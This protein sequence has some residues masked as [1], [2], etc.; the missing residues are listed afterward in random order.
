M[1][2][3]ARAL[4]RARFA[5]VLPVH[6]AL[7]M[8]V[9]RSVTGSL[10]G[11]WPLSAEDGVNRTL[12]AHREPVLDGF[13]QWLSLLANTQVITGLTLACVLALLLTPPAPRWAEAGFLAA[14][15]AVQS[16]MFLL[17]TLV[18][19]RPRPDV[20]HLDLAPP[21]SSFPSGHVGAAVA[22]YGGLAVL[23]RVGTRGAWR[24]PV[25]ALLLL[26]PLAVATSRLYRGMHHPSDVLGGLLNGAVTLAVIGT[27]LLSG[28]RR[29]PERGGAPSEAAPTTPAAG[30]S[31]RSSPN[32]PA[33]SGVGRTVVV[34]HPHGCDDALAERVGAVLTRHGHAAQQWIL[35]GEDL[36]CGEL[37]AELDAAAV[38][39]VVVCGGDGTVR[40]CAELLAGT[41]IELV[42][43]PCGTGNLLARNLGLAPD[44]VTAL[45]EALSGGCHGID[46]GRMRG[47]GIEPARFVVMAGVGFDAAMVQDA[48]PR[49]KS[50]LGW[51]AYVVSA[52]RHL[53]DPGIRLTIRLDGGR[54]LRRR[55]RMVVIGNVGMLQGG[56]PLLPE[57]RADDGRLDVVLFAPGGPAGWLAAAAHLTRRTLRAPA[58]RR[59]GAGAGDVAGGALEYFSATRVEIRCT[60]PQPREMDGDAVAPGV[61]LTVEIDRGALRVRLPRALPGTGAE[62]PPA[63]ALPA[64]APTPHH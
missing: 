39:L 1:S 21:T 32:P 15:V 60:A 18:V 56:L 43:V 17:V 19:E 7:L 8:V 49:L 10:A 29:A 30:E 55:A 3:P 14:A 44:P 52:L 36:P 5:L 24:R 40:A 13:T 53:G 16:A 42:V 47:D 48:S 45:E 62:A 50:R 12:A 54:P 2:P 46:V 34:R 9:G 64:A 59:P 4:R 58:S 6:L 27:V 61:R 22:L 37:A 25:A 63:A 31:V 51:A 20:P 33:S 11:Y 38:A 57:A 35:T 28:R 41:G 23:T 26:V